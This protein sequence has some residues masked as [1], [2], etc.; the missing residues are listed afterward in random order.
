[1]NG[2]FG[3]YHLG[4]IIPHATHIYIAVTISGS[5]FRPVVYKILFL[6]GQFIPGS[7]IV[8]A[9]GLAPNAHIGI[10]GRNPL[11]KVIVVVSLVAP[12]SILD[13]PEKKTKRSTLRWFHGR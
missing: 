3:G 8:Y 7:C 6:K 12:H 13:I 11:N 4:I 1:M 2:R 9:A 10:L 5:Q